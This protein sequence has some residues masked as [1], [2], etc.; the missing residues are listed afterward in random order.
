MGG[1][2]I[3]GIMSSREKKRIQ[4]SGFGKRPGTR[5]EGGEAG[6]ALRG[7][8]AELS[9][10]G[11]LVI[12]LEG[13]DIL[14]GTFADEAIVRPYSELLAQKGDHRTMIIDSPTEDLTEDLS[15]AL[16]AFGLVMIAVVGGKWCVLGVL[17]PQLLATLVVIMN[18]P[19]LS[20]KEIATEL[21]IKPAACH[22]R[23][24][25]LADMRLVRLEETGKPAP[26][27]RFTVHSILE[28]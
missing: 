18:R 4:I 14:S 27:T 22:R 2:R 11:Q 6:E 5:V 1:G 19:V 8:L 7:A 10:D 13:L 12:S 25:R 9:M 17:P 23:I 3:V 15:R 20:V 28:D 26:K 21:D 24:G 16:S